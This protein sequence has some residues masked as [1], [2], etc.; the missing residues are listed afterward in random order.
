MKFT[1][2]TFLN[3]YE[4][5]LDKK[6]KEIKK[7][8]TQEIE[9]CQALGRAT[10]GLIVSP[11]PDPDTIDEFKNHLES[12]EFEK[13]ERIAHFSSV[14]NSIL[15]LVK[16][17]NFKPSLEFEKEVI[18]CN[19]LDFIVSDSAMLRLDNFYD[20]LKMQLTDVKEEITTLREKIRHLWEKLDEDPKYSNEFIQQHTGNTLD[21]LEALRK[22]LERLETL[23]RS[24]IEV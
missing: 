4:T 1:V 16:E 7:C 10:K 3:R 2:F 11:L 12:L 5:I 17:L 14:K 20:S 19:E 23:R 21:T 8:N 15:E 18:S 9:L 24:N 6:R 13:Y 22:E